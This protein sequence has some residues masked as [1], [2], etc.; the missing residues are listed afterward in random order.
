MDHPAEYIHLKAP[1]ASR[2]PGS[3][4]FPLK[5]T[6]DE[7]NSETPGMSLGAI[8]RVHQHRLQVPPC[9]FGRSGCLG[10]EKDIYEQQ[11]EQQQQ[12]QEQ[13]NF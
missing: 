12:Q 7:L 8:L 6:S 4:K 2:S 9:P 10:R 13:R 1:E 11:Y 3:L 5:I